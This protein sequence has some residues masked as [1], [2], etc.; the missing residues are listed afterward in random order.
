MRRQ[1]QNTYQD[2]EYF[3]KFADREIGLDEQAQYKAYVQVVAPAVKYNRLNRAKPFTSE[4]TVS[5]NFSAIEGSSELLKE[6]SQKGFMFYFNNNDKELYRRNIEDNTLIKIQDLR[7]YKEAN[8]DFS[9]ALTQDKLDPPKT[10]PPKTDPPKTDL[11]ET[12][13]NLTNIPVLQMQGQN[14][15][16]DNDGN[17]I[18]DGKPYTKN[19]ILE[20]GR[21]VPYYVP[22]VGDK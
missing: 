10:D 6:Y 9:F 18:I 8:P 7:N 14:V 15:P 19:M 11:P 13:G 21:D 1:Y 17:Y 12:D 20:N 5:E 16:Q 4:T 3:D 22:I 2:N